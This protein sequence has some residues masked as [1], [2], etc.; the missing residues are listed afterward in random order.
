[1]P[2][3]GLRPRPCPP[4]GD[5]QHGP[6]AP[7]RV[8]RLLGR[9]GTRVRGSRRGPGLVSSP[10]QARRGRDQPR[11]RPL[12]VVRGRARP[13]LPEARRPR[14]PR[15]RGRPCGVA[16]AA[17]GEPARGPGERHGR[18]GRLRR[19]ARRG[20][21]DPRPGRGSPRTRAAVLGPGKL[22]R[23]VAAVLRAAGA[24]VALLGRT[25]RAKAASF[26]LVVEAT[27]S[28]EGIGRALA[29]V[30]PRGTIVWKRTHH[31]PARFDAAP[32]VVN[33]VTVVG[34][35]CGRFEPALDLLRRGAWTSGR[36]FRRSS[37]SASG[38]RLARGR[39]PRRPEGPPEALKPGPGAPRR[40]E[41]L[42]PGS[43][44]R[45]LLPDEHLHGRH[46]LRGPRHG[47]LPRRLRHGRDAASTRTRR[48][49]SCSSSGIS[50]IYEPG[51][52]ELIHKNEKAGRLRFSTERR[53]GDRALARDLHR[54]RDAAEGATARP[55]LSFIFQVAETIAEH[56]NGYKV[57]RDEV[58]RPDGNR[59][60]DRGDPQR[61]T[62]ST[63]S[64]SSRTPSSSARARRSRT[65]CD[66][67][68]S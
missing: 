59:R 16:H 4:F 65:S 13:A 19:A 63:S 49:S 18:G 11:L 54:G 22:G 46:G 60:A 61:R 9:P 53:R 17:G 39:A 7:A 44:L 12:F 42:S 32:L 52:E 30:R 50:P 56:M 8:P 43:H 66:P 35:R 62:G 58:D 55:D 27:G 67:T 38:A 20:L 1:M 15:P 37:R 41:S 21:R 40:V 24:E 48:R 47:R 33:E 51:L 25:N 31:A 5:L 68:A 45:R 3:R 10:R 2:R 29:L 64:R 28:P 6:R 57:R 34:S 26:D 36:S 23:L 14:D